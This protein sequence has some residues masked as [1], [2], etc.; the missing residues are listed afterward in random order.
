MV[1]NL[2]LAHFGFLPSHDQYRLHGSHAKVIVILLRE[3]FT[4]KLIH[5]SHFSC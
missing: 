4:A 2:T 1:G 5:L 3:L